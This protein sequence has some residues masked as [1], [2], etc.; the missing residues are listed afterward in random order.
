MSDEKFD[1]QVDKELGLAA[2]KDIVKVLEREESVAELTRWLREAPLEE[3][4]TVRFHIANLIQS[5][6]EAL[7]V[8]AQKEKKS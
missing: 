4:K 1:K 2:F 5:L 7:R 6:T 8:A 3:T